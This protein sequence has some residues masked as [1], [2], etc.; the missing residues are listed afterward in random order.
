M[1]DYVIVYENC[2]VCV[3]GTMPTH[4]HNEGG[5]VT[6]H[7]TEPCYVEQCVDGWK[8]LNRI[9]VTD[10]VSKLDTLD[11]HLDT[12]ETKIDALE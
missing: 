10:I 1:A 7:M 11:A 8:V 5:S 9:D 4:T 6:E 3:D 2:N 12:L